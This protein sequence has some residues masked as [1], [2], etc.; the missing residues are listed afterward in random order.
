M[1]Y[2]SVCGI[3]RTLLV[4]ANGKYFLPFKAHLVS[5]EFLQPKIKKSLLHREVV[6]SEFK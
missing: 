6:I 5:P 3:F 1:S 2:N 4:F